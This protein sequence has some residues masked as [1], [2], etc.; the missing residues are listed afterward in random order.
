MA[1]SGRRPLSGTSGAPGGGGGE[2]SS[3]TGGFALA[4]LAVNQFVGELQSVVGQMQHFVEALSPSTVQMLSQA[5]RDMQATIGQAFQPALV[6]VTD[7]VRSIADQISPVAQ[8]LA[9][10]FQQL[11]SFIGERLVYAVNLA[12]G[13]VEALIPAFAPLL[14]VVRQLSD[15]YAGQVVIVAALVTA[16]ISSAVAAFQSV[17]P[18]IDV[19][20]NAVKEFAR[21][22]ILTT[23]TLFKLFG[24]TD[25]LAALVAGFNPQQGGRVLAAGPTQITGL[26]EITKQLALSAAQA[27]GGGEV[28][29]SQDQWLADIGKDVGKIAESGPS[30]MDLLKTLPDRIARAI[31]GESGD[32]ASSEQGKSVAVPPALGFI[33]PLLTLPNLLRR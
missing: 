14:D 32:A 1:R 24:M 22:V 3:I 19:V 26:E 31:R 27:R 15:A 6:V 5:F 20:L 7:V 16:V 33:H 11:A 25:A 23:A 17:K 2:G 30:L 21:A 18:V 29:K 12:A 28:A 10:V 9:P 13:A 8:R 4:Q